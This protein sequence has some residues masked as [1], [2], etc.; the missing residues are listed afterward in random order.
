MVAILMIGVA[1]WTHVLIGA[2]VSGLQTWFGLLMFLVVAVLLV[3]ISTQLRLIDKTSYLPTLCY[4]LLIGG[5]PEIHAFNSAIIAAILLAVGFIILVRSFESERI[6]YGYFTAAMVISTATFFYTYMYVYIPA[7]WGAMMLWRRPGYWREWVFTLLGFALPLFLA[8]SWFF[9]IDGDFVRMVSFFKALVD[10]QRESASLSI[11]SAIIMIVGIATAVL[12]F[13]HVSRYIGSKK[14]IVR[15]GYYILFL[16]A[17][18][19]VG[20]V[21]VV[22][23]AIPQVWYLLA[24]PLSF[25]LSNYLATVKSTR[26]GTAVLATLFATVTVAQAIYCFAALSL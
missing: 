4:V 10:T 20:L 12:T 26:W 1:T 8:F 23:D 11:P 14:I 2:S 25:F 13:G 15:N 3:Y 24:F 17:I 22:P 9:L 18:A 21:C 6:S 16:M 5:V 7:M 19:T